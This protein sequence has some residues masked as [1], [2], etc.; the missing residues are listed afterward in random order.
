MAEITPQVAGLRQENVDTFKRLAQRLGRTTSRHLERFSCREVTASRGDPVFIIET[1]W[2][3][4]A[5]VEETLGTKGLVAD[6]MYRLTGQS[7]YHDTAQCAVAM[8]VNDLITCGALPHSVA[9]HLAVGDTHWFHNERRSHDLLSGWRSACELAGCAMGGGETAILED[10]IHPE[11]FVLGGSAV[12]CVVPKQ[13]LIR[14]TI[15]DGDAIVL[16]ASTGIHANGI[17]AARRLAASLPQGYRTKMADGRMFGEALLDQTRIYVPILESTQNRG[18]EIHAWIPITGLGWRKLMRA[19]EPF[20][21]VIDRVPEPQPIFGFLQEH[22]QFSDE[23]MFAR[24][25]MGAGLAIIGPQEQV[26]ALC[27]VIHGHGVPAFQAGHVERCKEKRVVILP[28]HIEFGAETLAI[29]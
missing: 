14:C 28:K 25:N 24:F 18:L 22:G 5:H 26:S 6:E 7:S 4:E 17:T 21:Y 23:G 29:R 27:E 3:Y 19:V 11:A 16:A 8:I 12:G 9:M 13:R 1:P 2:G 20:V 15:R 10:V